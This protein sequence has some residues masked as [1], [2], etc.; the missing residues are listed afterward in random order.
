MLAFG[1]L[2]NGE[3][4]IRDEI[5]RV[6]REWIGGMKLDWIINRFRECPDESE[7]IVVLREMCRRLSLGT[8]LLGDRDYTPRLSHAFWGNTCK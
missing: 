3:D 8:T 4:E 7:G 2:W 5:Y 6:E 1:G